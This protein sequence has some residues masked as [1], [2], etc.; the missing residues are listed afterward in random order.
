[1]STISKPF[2]RKK[3]LFIRKNFY[4]EKIQNLSPSQ[5]YAFY[6]GYFS[7][8]RILLS[9]AEVPITK[10]SGFYPI[11][12][13]PDC[14]FLLDHLQTHGFET[15]LPYIEKKNE[16]MRFL[17]YFT[18][19]TKFTRDIFGT[20]APDPLL[21][22]VIQPQ[23]F[24]VP[25][26]AFSSKGARLGYGGGYYDKYLGDLRENQKKWNKTVGLAFECLKCEEIQ[27]E[28]HDIPL[29]YVITEKEIYT[30]REN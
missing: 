22:A 13:E 18:N 28:I 25:L 23:F 10:I 3:F 14:I 19:Q 5:Y 26:L 27:S 8:L 17:Q 12:H 30:T 6:V 9:Q 2:L 4:Q 21:S 29:D 20:K 15:A 1:M 11:K 16:K 24:I 7:K